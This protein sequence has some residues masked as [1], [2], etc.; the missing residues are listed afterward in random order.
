MTTLPCSARKRYNNLSQ[1]MYNEIMRVSEPDSI[2]SYENVEEMDL[3]KSDI[4]DST[5]K[6]FAEY[7]N[8]Y[9]ATT[10][11]VTFC[12]QWKKVIRDLRA[13]VERRLLVKESLKQDISWAIIQANNGNSL[14]SYKDLATLKDK[15]KG[16]E[17][18]DFFMKRASNKDEVEYLS[19]FFDAYFKKE[20]IMELNFQIFDKQWDTVKAIKSKIKLNPGLTKDDLFINDD[21]GELEAMLLREKDYY[22]Y[23]G[24][25]WFGEFGNFDNW[26][27]PEFLMYIENMQSNQAEK[28]TL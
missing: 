7:R 6:Q 5:F 1:C 18:K 12:N 19:N 22:F 17:V 24:K 16:S 21:S 23:N 26:G 8:E 4:Q 25:L 14:T 9:G 2:L 10:Y 20:V 13:L 15:D 27:R 11:E 3:L 28:N